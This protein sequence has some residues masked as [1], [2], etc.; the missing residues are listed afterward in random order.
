[1]YILCKICMNL[2]PFTGYCIT[3]VYTYIHVPPLI[4]EWAQV[5]HINLRTYTLVLCNCSVEVRMLRS[6][7]GI[8]ITYICTY[9]VP[10][11]ISNI[12]NFLWSDHP[13]V[14]VC[15]IMCTCTGMCSHELGYNV[16]SIQ[17]R[18]LV[19]KLYDSFLVT[20][21][22]QPPTPSPATCVCGDSTGASPVEPVHLRGVS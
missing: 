3:S 7:R 20:F 22:G 13:C 1:M 5:L 19:Y 8:I 16:P 9:E 10:R 15:C 17:Q 11:H 4:K 18:C 14:C 6:L 12:W 21:P 2:T